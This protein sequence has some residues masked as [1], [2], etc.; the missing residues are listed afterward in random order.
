MG[1][2]VRWRYEVLDKPK[3]TRGEK[4]L[5]EAK[6]DLKVAKQDCSLSLTLTALARCALAAP[7]Y[8]LQP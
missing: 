2:C 3:Y 4:E 8:S 1:D 5:G 7:S 6:G